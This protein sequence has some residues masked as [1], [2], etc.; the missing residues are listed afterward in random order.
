MTEENKTLVWRLFEEVINTGDLNRADALVD[1]DFV[2][3]NPAPG[4]GTGL[5]G[6]KLLMAMLRAAFPDLRITID[7]LVAEDD[8]VSVR[9][10]ARGT[11]EGT[12][13][14]VPATGNRVAWEGISMLRISEGRI[15]E[16]WF[17][18]D[19]AGLMRQLGGEA[20]APG[21]PPAD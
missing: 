14:G 5:D 1:R 16:R 2:E 3:H 15:A 4:Q 18:A 21:P 20:Q 10:T 13:A 8:K 7:E 12:F 19:T 9:L 11:H 17:H 6:F